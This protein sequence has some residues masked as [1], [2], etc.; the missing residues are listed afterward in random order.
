DEKYAEQTVRALKAAGVPI[1]V[2][3]DA[4]NPGTAHG[5]SLHRELELLVRAGLSPVEALAAATSAPAA[6]FH[7]SDRGEIAEGKR[8]DLLLVEGD[9]TR[10]ITATRA[11]VGVWKEGKRINRDKYREA[12]EQ[13][14]ANAAKAE[15][16][17]ATGGGPRLISD[18]ED[19]QPTAKFGAG[20]S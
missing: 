15:P 4:P 13:A 17:N 3:T 11:I 14:T 10:D 6:A 8:S 18:F 12:I 7:L 16:A 2:G 5:A 1:L 9:P 19:N 20:W